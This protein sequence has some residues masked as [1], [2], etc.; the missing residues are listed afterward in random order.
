MIFGPEG[1]PQPLAHL[2]PLPRQLWLLFVLRPPSPVHDI[3]ETWALMPTPSQSL[4]DEP[5]PFRVHKVSSSYPFNVNLFQLLSFAV[6]ATA[7]VCATPTL[8]SLVQ[9]LI[10][11]ETACAVFH[12]RRS[13]SLQEDSPDILPDCILALGPLCRPANL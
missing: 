5:A 8:L 2:S 12:Q 7:L 10:T 9:Q 11:R 4:S 1:A 6:L 13:Q 3:I